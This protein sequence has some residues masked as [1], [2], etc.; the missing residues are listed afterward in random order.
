MLIIAIDPGKT[1]GWA[2]D[3]GV[4]ITS[5]QSEDI[6]AWETL[7]QIRSN[8]NVEV[9]VLERPNS[10]FERTDH[11]VIEN[12]GVIKEWARQHSIPVVLQTPSQGKHFYSDS[13]LEKLG[14]FRT[15][16]TPWRHAND[17]M[18]HLLYYENFGKRPK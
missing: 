1:M 4:F 10:G 6:E 8:R 3:D 7:D 16:K 14:R 12:C 15:P 2:Q 13:K 18:R 17:A 5:W 11:V 9:I